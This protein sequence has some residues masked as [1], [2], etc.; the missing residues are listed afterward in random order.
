MYG[1][2]PKVGDRGK[3]KSCV[4]MITEIKEEGDF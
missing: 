1:Y 2:M 3:R 4:L